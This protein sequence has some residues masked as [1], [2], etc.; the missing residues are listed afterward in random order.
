MVIDAILEAIPSFGEESVNAASLLP[1][2][3]IGEPAAGR[4]VPRL[5]ADIVVLTDSL[6]IKRVLVGGAD[7]V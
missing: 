7:V 5:P 4:L 2:R 1:A 6:E 3:V